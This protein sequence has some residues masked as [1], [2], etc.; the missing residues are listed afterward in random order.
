M[1][2]VMRTPWPMRSAPHTWSAWWMPAPV[3]LTCVDGERDVLA[4]QVLE[5]VEVVGGR[6][7]VLR[8]CDVEA[9]DTGVPEG[10]GEIGG[11]AQ[12][13]GHPHAAQEGADPDRGAGR[14]RLRQPAAS[15]SWTVSTTSGRVSPPLV[16]CSGA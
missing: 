4:A 16:F 12:T 11:L 3:R 5:G 9:D 7:A 2:S 10:D 13:V 6:E 15:P 1:S 14:G 8:A